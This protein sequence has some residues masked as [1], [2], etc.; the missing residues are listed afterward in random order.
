MLHRYRQ[1]YSLHKNIYDVYVDTA[2][3]VETKFDIMNYE[4]ER[5]LRKEKDKKVIGLMKDKLGQKIMT[6]FTALR[7]KIYSYLI[8]GGDEDQK[9]K[10][11]KSVS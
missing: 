4:I 3:D 11:T 5:P 10:G 6:E 9:A 1:L 7:P 8:D 2:K